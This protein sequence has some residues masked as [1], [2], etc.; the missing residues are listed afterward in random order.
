MHTMLV[1]RA[2]NIKNSNEDTMEARSSRK[3]IKRRID[4]WDRGEFTVLLAEL[5]ESDEA[6]MDE[7]VAARLID[8]F[9][10]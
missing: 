1:W 9:R 4:L 7:F 10:F 3:K 8:W 5:R 2:D 6:M